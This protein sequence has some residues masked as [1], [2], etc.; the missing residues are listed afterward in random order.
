MVDPAHPPSALLA[1]LA[2]TQV[3]YDVS[4]IPTASAPP[5]SAHQQSAVPPPCTASLKPPNVDGG[6]GG[7]GLHV[8]VSAH[9]QAVSRHRVLTP[10]R[11]WDIGFLDMQAVEKINETSRS[12]FLTHSPSPK[13]AFTTSQHASSGESK[14]R[15]S[16]WQRKSSR[17][18]P[19]CPCPWRCPCWHS[20]CMRCGRLAQI[21]CAVATLGVQRW[22]CG[23]KICNW[24]VSRGEEERTEFVLSSLVREQ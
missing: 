18:L 19:R 4:Y 11:Y 7:G 16:C 10:P 6:S 2:H 12:R 22:R 15:P 9:R 8:G 5:P 1:F 23:T 21:H 20:H 3:S 24:M 17:H 14:R 13:I